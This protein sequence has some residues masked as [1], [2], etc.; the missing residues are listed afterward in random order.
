MPQA[1]RTGDPFNHGGNMGQGSPD[2]FMEG[3][4]VARVG[5]MVNCPPPILGHNPNPMAQGS[6]TVFVNGKPMVRVGD[7]AMCGGS[8]LK[9]APTVCADDGV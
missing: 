4:G 6:P 1:V 9:G 5:D 2:V 3:I 8:M 7:R